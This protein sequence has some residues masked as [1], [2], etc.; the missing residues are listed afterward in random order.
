M[1]CKYAP[2]AC[3]SGVYAGECLGGCAHWYTLCWM[4]IGEMNGRSG[5]LMA[6]F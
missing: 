2:V 5:L 4:W 3:A 6:L 1:L